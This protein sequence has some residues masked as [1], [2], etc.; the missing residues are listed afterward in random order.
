MQQALTILTSSYNLSKPDSKFNIG[1]DNSAKGIELLTANEIDIAASSRKMTSAE[2]SRFYLKRGMY[3]LEYIVS[4]SEIILAGHPNLE[5]D[6]ISINQLVRGFSC[7]ARRG[8]AGEIPYGHFYSQ[9][10]K[11]GT[12]KIFSDFLRLTKLCSGTKPVKDNT[13]MRENLLTDSLAVG[14]I[15]VHFADSL[16][17]IK[18]IGENDQSNPAL[19]KRY[20][21]LYIP[22]NANKNVTDFL[23]YCLS[24]KAQQLLSDNGYIPVW[25]SNEQ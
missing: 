20:L 6:S 21:Y 11:S 22:E 9:D 15:S 14:Y 8:R 25:L 5:F 4:K 16:K 3:P 23:N 1:S 7:S 19:L 24:E 12:T 10:P 17:Q 18:I 13:A 2:I